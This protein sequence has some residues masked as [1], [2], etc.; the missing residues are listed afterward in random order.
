MSGSTLT[1][2]TSPTP[3][4][5]CPSPENHSWHLCLHCKTKGKLPTEEHFIVHCMNH[6]K[7]RSAMLCPPCVV[8]NVANNSTPEPFQCPFHGILKNIILGSDG[9]ESKPQQATAQNICVMKSRFCQVAFWK[10]WV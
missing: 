4:P 10:A 9:R 6:F 5:V 1:T 3:T 8:T 7:S 2:V